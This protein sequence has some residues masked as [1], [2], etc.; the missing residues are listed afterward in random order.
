M[1]LFVRLLLQ[2]AQWSRRRPKRYLVI[3]V[4]IA[5]VVIVALVA[6][7]RFIGWP[8]ALTVNRLPRNPMPR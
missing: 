3:T 2:M 6:I 8:D 7:E 4:C 5:A 1:D